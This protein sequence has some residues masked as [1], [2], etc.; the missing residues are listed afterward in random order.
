MIKDKSSAW[1]VFV[2]VAV[3]GVLC[4]TCGGG[5]LVRRQR[6]L[7]NTVCSEF[8][9][10][11]LRFFYRLCCS[12]IATQNWAMQPLKIASLIYFIVSDINSFT[13]FR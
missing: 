11:L 7:K 2:V 10:S 5:I 1:S 4:D 8:S 3:F 6:T 13:K 12:R 9:V